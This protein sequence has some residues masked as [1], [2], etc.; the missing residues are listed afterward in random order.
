[1]L[2]LTA[3]ILLRSHYYAKEQRD[4]P[5]ETIFTDITEQQ[6]AKAV[7]SHYLKKTDESGCQPHYLQRTTSNVFFNYRLS[8]FVLPD[9][10]G[11]LQNGRQTSSMI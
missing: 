1:M 11:H 4:A 8:A 6:L 7:N 3:I 9:F 2:G 10:L 5:F